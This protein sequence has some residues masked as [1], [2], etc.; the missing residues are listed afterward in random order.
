MSGLSRKKPDRPAE[1]LF[2]MLCRTCG[3]DMALKRM[4][5]LGFRVPKEYAE[6]AKEREQKEFDEFS[7]E[8]LKDIH[9]GKHG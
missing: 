5:K 1:E 8:L 7:T 6:F 3:V 2:D 4:K 9:G